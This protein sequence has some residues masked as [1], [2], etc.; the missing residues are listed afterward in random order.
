MLNAIVLGWA[1]T[2]EA[3][4]STFGLSRNS[5]HGG[6]GHHESTLWQSLLRWVPGDPVGARQQAVLVN[7]L[8]ATRAAFE[9]SMAGLH[10]ESAEELMR[11][12]RGSRELADLW[13]LRTWLYNELAR[14]FSQREA[15]FRLDLLNQHFPA[16]VASALARANSRPH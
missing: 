6:S 5:R 13:H 16:S 9:A 3:L 11:C 10:G 12:I 4:S 7:N 15:E 14:G 2:R 1:K 8:P